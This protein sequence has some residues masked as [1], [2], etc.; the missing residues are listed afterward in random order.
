M[1]WGNY[2]SKLQ[3]SRVNV[4]VINLHIISA[5]VTRDLTLVYL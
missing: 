1:Y 3:L 4:K 2:L 5:I